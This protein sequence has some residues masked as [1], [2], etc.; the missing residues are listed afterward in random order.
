MAKY[1]FLTPFT[2]NNGVTIKNRIVMAPMTEMS[3]FENGIVTNDEIEYYRLRSGGIGME[4]TGCANV[5]DLGKGFEGELSA[6]KDAVLPQLSKLA[7]AMKS[8]GTKAILQ[9]FNAGCMT[10]SKILRG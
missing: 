10:T 2:L 4:I 9:I 5:S 6:S 1:N 7:Q 8:N 3:S